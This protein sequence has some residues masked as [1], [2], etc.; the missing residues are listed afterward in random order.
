MLSLKQSADAEGTE[1]DDLV[2]IGKALRSHIN[3]ATD[4]PISPEEVPWI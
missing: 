2:G 4:E 1:L 3:N